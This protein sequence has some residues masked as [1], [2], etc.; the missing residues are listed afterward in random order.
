MRGNGIGK[1]DGT[2][3]FCR[4]DGRRKKQG[5]GVQRFKGSAVQGTVLLSSPQGMVTSLIGE[6]WTHG[7]GQGEVTNETTAPPGYQL[8]VNLIPVHFSDS[9][10]G[11]LLSVSI[12]ENLASLT[13]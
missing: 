9:V 7:C 4:F 3:I 8:A 10:R 5:S 2:G 13:Q 12:S 6:V 1:T 11:F